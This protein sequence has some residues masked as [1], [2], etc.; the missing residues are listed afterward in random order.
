VDAQTEQLAA[1]LTTEVGK[2][3]AQSRNELKGLAP[4]LDFFI[5]ETARTLRPKKVSVDVAGSMEERISHE[6]LG[7]VANISA[8]NYPWYVG[9][10]VFLPALLT[11]NA[12]L[13]KPSELATL[14]GLAIADLLHEA[15]VPA[16]AFQAVVGGG[17]VGAA[18]IAEPVDAVCFTGSLATG[19]KVA[20]AVAPRLLKL[21]LEL[22]GKD[23]AYVCEDVDP[24]AAAAA[25]AEGAF[26]NTGQSCCAVE[27]VYV[28][29]RVA[30]PFVEAFVGTVKGYVVGDP[31]DERTDVGPLTRREAALS[32][33]EEQVAE[34]D[35][36]LAIIG[37]GWLDAR[38]WSGRHRWPKTLIASLVVGRL[39]Q[40]PV[41]HR[42]DEVGV[43]E[44]RHEF[45][46]RELAELRMAPA[47]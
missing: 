16:D 36:L 1:V 47:Q 43:L 18:L 44:D 3:I 34:C 24:A 37:K 19:R 30:R 9:A 7:V 17:D 12:V 28:H 21:Q 13:Y 45:R 15:G 35:V 4:R 31:L 10:N 27:R 38:A 29:E 14:T 39:Y 23:P 42:D 33:L 46:G 40:H 2:P 41:A 20:A 6:P 11:G 22:G 5:A 32:L 8:W 26:Y 25:V